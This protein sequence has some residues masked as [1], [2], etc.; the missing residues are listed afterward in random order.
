MSQ[1][2]GNDRLDPRGCC[3]TERATTAITNRPGQNTLNY[4]LGTHPSFLRSML[5]VLHRLRIPEGNNAGK[6]PLEKLA[7]RS[8]DDA[9]LA[10]LDAWA[11]VAD[12]LTFYQERIANEG[13][14]RTATERRSVLEL[15]RTIG[16]EL[17]PGVAASTHLAFTVDDSKGTPDEVV[18]PT[19]T[20]V[21]SIPAQSGDLPQTFETTEEFTAH[22]E[23]NEIS[24][25][26]SKPWP[27]TVG[28]DR[29]YLKGVDTN[30]R[31]GDPILIVGDEREKSPA[32]DDWNRWDFR[33]LNTV[34]PLP[35]EGFTEVT[36]D[37]GLGLLLDGDIRE[38]ATEKPRIYALRQRASLF[39]HNAP[40]WLA[41]AQQFR[42]EYAQTHPDES[43]TL[44]E[45][46]VFCLGHNMYM[47]ATCASENGR[48][49]INADGV[50][51]SELGILIVDN[52]RPNAI[53]GMCHLDQLTEP[54]W[55]LFDRTI[56]WAINHQDHATTKIWLATF[57]GTLDP[58]QGD[59]IG[60]AAYNH[61]LH[62]GFLACNI[63]VANQVT[64]E[65]S[66][67]TDYDLVLYACTDMRHATNVMGQNVPF[68][69]L[70]VTQSEEMGIGTGVR[71]MHEN[72]KHAFVVD[73]THD[74]TSPES[75]TPPP[76]P[77]EW[78][79]F[80]TIPPA[81]GGLPIFHLD[82]EYPKIVENS[83]IALSKADLQDLYRAVGVNV[84]SRVD[85]TLTAKV[86]QITA[87]TDSGNQFDS[88]G[89]R[90]TE[91][92]AQSDEIQQ[93]EQPLQLPVFG[94]EIVLDG[95][96]E[97]LLEGQALVFRGKTAKSVKVGKLTRRMTF[98][99][100]PTERT[101]RIEL[102][103]EAVDCEVWTFESG[104]TKYILY[105]VGEESPL[106]FEPE[107]EEAETTELVAGDIL[108]IAGPPTIDEFGRVKWHLTNLDGAKGHVTAQPDDLIPIPTVDEDETNCE[109]AEIDKV[110]H[111]EENTTIIL[112]DSLTNVYDRKT[113]KI[114]AN[115]VHATHGE[116]I[117][118]EVLGSGDGSKIDQ[119]FQLQR[120]PLT[121]V[122]AP[123]PTGTESSLT[124]RVDG[125]EWK[126]EPSLYELNGD[127]RAYFVRI[128]N[129][130]GA[131]VIFGDGKKGARLPTGSENVVA[132]YRS[133]IGP[134]GEVAAGALSLLKKRPLGIREVSNPLP[135]TGAAGPEQLES[136]RSN[137]PLKVVT[138]DRIVSLRD[139]EDFARAF[140]GI[141]K[142]R[143]MPMR[144]GEA[145]LV[146]ITV[147]GA[148]GKEVRKDSDLYENL[149]DG[150]DAARDPLMD[151]IVDSYRLRYFNVEASIAVDGTYLRDEVLSEVEGVL[152]DIFS[153]EK[154][155]FG[156]PVTVAKL[157]Q[158]VHSVAGVVAADV[159]YL[160]A[161]KT[162]DD[163]DAPK[164]LTSVLSA[165][166]PDLIKG[167]AELLLIN[168]TGITL[169][170]MIP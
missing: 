146:H 32:D 142:A 69:T 151:V 49:L 35:E 19:I 55:N 6:Y 168:E 48:T 77:L 9:A 96:I 116:A 28:T 43:V 141:G 59:E 78:P 147:A 40:D 71:T 20:Q 129:D 75:S 84:V 131:S 138:M 14:L 63:Y 26:K 86:T 100:D 21:L 114:Y 7:T 113:V 93:A 95:L 76:V 29:L 67:F 10:L 37:H 64:I 118:G 52:T 109:V 17:S 81:N 50:S 123:T 22:A 74:I 62:M 66:S 23:W 169:T 128:D 89:L 137:A 24:P 45:L 92:F 73:N 1:T 58:D 18:I 112:A 149:V 119:R 68:V 2:A 39:G 41:M 12:V 44:F 27:L 65:T 16:Y 61:L 153:F 150:I 122:S 104:G 57:N 51:G 160:Y 31:P 46:G 33:I 124:V 125:V 115:V 143:A 159:D 87:D 126:E 72:R 3:E 80:F 83:W 162:D 110:L 133:G 130:A 60:Q 70:C 164:S 152:L 5:E 139:F 157:M 97:G 134:E 135:A 88:F 140:A 121:Y 4:R 25:C 132:T 108:D 34:T 56:D 42:Q 53:F 161:A 94:R 136:A 13:F 85:Y 127:A 101:V 99:E 36:F 8:S 79:P 166:Q 167:G 170:E 106:S 107:E 158:V 30:L 148:S 47:D 90:E 155:Q 15:A 103:A 91:V 154:R 98:E 165:V 117:P 105:N 54:G 11:A 145:E 163:N 82:Q 156:Q 38:P 102:A 111:G 144:N 120:I